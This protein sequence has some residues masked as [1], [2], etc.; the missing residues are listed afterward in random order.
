M[1]FWL[2]LLVGCWSATAD[3]PPIADASLRVAALRAVFPGMRISRPS[4]ASTYRVKGPVTNDAEKCASGDVPSLRV[5]DLRDVES[6][7]FGWP[8][9][10]GSGLIAV[11]QYKFAGVSPPEACFSIAMLA[12]VSRTR[13]AWRVSEHVLFE[14]THHYTAP[15]ARMLDLTGDGVD[16]LAV[17]SDWGGLGA[18]DVTED[19]FDL[20][21]G[22]FEQVLEVFSRYEGYDARYT[23][24]LDIA[25]TRQTHATQFCF[26]RTQTAENGQT[27][28]APKTSTPCYKP[29]NGIQVKI[30][31]ER[32]EMLKPLHAPAP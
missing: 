21:R 3:T 8:N 9:A 2:L 20:H 5:S 24:K 22:S 26:V 28:P 23:Q 16:D 6:T 12:H 11:L 14:T 1:K 31:A 10:K 7:L 18:S 15:S 30:N 25:R 29:G 4:T 19:I 17:D 27:L 13:S 32:N